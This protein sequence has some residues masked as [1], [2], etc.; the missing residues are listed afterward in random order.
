[1]MLLLLLLLL[2]LERPSVVVAPH[3][4]LTPGLA[5]DNKCRDAEVKITAENYG[6]KGCCRGPETFSRFKHFLNKSG[7]QF[8]TSQRNP[9]D[10]HHQAQRILQQFLLCPAINLEIV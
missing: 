9:S 5:G 2:L 3:L 8:I 6:D 1:M 10:M 7:D 4:S